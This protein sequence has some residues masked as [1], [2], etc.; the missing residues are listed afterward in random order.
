M[1][2]IRQLS[3]CRRRPGVKNEVITSRPG[4]P[5]P[6]RDVISG[7]VQRAVTTAEFAT[8][9]ALA[10]GFGTGSGW[11]VISHLAPGWRGE[12]DAEGTLV[13]ERR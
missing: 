8:P 13:L 11:Q 5:R 12:W 4:L 6:G 9:A 10:V 7:V 1:P 2:E 3:L